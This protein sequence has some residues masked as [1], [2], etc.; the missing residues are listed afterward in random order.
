MK[1]WNVEDVNVGD[2]TFR[3][4]VNRAG[5]ISFAAMNRRE[6]TMEGGLLTPEHALE[7]ANNLTAAAKLAKE[8]IHVQ[9][10]QT[11]NDPKR[12]SSNGR[13]RRGR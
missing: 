11:R 4:V 9:K 5:N 2:R 7:I 10:E 8:Q 13:R 6:S 12:R 1:P 3:V